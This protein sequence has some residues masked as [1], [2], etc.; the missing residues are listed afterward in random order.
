LLLV[1]ILNGAHKDTF[2]IP[3]NAMMVE[4]FLPGKPLL[5]GEKHPGTAAGVTL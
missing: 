2:S 3:A 5:Q 1:T 4:H